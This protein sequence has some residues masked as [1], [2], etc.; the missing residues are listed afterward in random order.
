MLFTK[1][2]KTRQSTKPEREERGGEGVNNTHIH[3]QC[4]PRSLPLPV[5]ALNTDRPTNHPPENNPPDRKGEKK[6]N[7]LPPITKAITTAPVLVRPLS[8]F[9]SKAQ[10]HAVFAAL[11]SEK[12]KLGIH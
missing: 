9:L 7:L 3:P 11:G 5:V 6:D 10:A 2:K 1:K 4:L 8:I 12:A